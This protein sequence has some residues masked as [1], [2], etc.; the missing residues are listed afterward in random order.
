MVW[1]RPLTHYTGKTG[2]FSKL[3]DGIKNVA[4]AIKKSGSSLRLEIQFLVNR[5]NESQIKEVKKFASEVNARLRLKSMQVLDQE[6]AEEWLPEGEN[7]SRYRKDKSRFIIKGRLKNRCLRL[8]LN[9][10]ITWDG[11]VI[12][13]CFDKNADHIFGDL[14]TQSF[15][16]IWHGEKAMQFRQSVS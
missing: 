6:R 12:P 1:T 10:V 15:S 5:Q 13:C 14:N 3:V 7:F 2:I 11:K 9:P 8:W 16:E 4:G